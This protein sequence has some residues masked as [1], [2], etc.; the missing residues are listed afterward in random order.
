MAIN[1]FFMGLLLDRLGMASIVECDEVHRKDAKDAK[2]AK[3]MQAVFFASFA[4]LASLR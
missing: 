1:D 3:E 2:D 4:L